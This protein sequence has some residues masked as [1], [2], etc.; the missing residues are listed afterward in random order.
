M[1]CGDWEFVICVDVFV[2]FLCVCG[3]G[4]LFVIEWLFDI[5]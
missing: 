1:W 2:Y 3:V 5:W 4:E